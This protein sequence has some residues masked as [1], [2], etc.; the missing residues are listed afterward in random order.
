M[1]PT[2]RLVMRRCGHV[3]ICLQYV[4]GPWRSYAP[5]IRSDL[6]CAAHGVVWQPNGSLRSGYSGMGC[7]EEWPA[8]VVNCSSGRGPVKPIHP[9][10]ISEK[11]AIVA[12]GFKSGNRPQPWP[13][14]CEV[15]DLSDMAKNLILWLVIAVVLMSLFQLQSQRF[16]TASW[17]KPF[18]RDV[19]QGQVR[20]VRINGKVINGVKRNGDKFLAVIPIPDNNLINDPAA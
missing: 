7:L 20:E 9:G 10:A 4:V 1:A 6:A 17:S 13:S 3:W 11:S 16:C 2:E 15:N 18:V 14:N 8:A 5:T 12:T 19:S